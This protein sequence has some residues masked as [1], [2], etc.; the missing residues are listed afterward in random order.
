MFFKD[1]RT[2]ISL[3]TTAFVCSIFQFNSSFLV[4]ALEKEK[5]VPVIYNGPIVSTATFF[6]VIS[7]IVSAK[8]VRYMPKRVF[9]FLSILCCGLSLF[10]MGPS[11]ILGLPN[12]FW[13]FMVG[14]CICFTTLGCIFIP[15]LPEI[16][17]SFCF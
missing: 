5:H 9:L 3:I 10:V 14:F 8:F 6:Y 2:I 13:I 11:Y 12:S 16:I 17:D 4:T 15:I 1:R 7:T